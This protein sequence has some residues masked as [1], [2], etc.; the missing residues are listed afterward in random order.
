MK[1]MKQIITLL[2]VVCMLASVV[3]MYAGAEIDRGIGDNL[4]VLG[5]IDADA[6]AVTLNFEEGG[7][8]TC[9]K[10]TG[11]EWWYS[12]AQRWSDGEHW[13]CVDDQDL[14]EDWFSENNIKSVTVTW[15]DGVSV[16]VPKEG[17]VIDKTTIV[18]MI[19]FFAIRDEFKPKPS[20]TVQPATPTPVAPTVQPATP[21]PTATPAAPTVQPATPTPAAP[22]VQPTVVPTVE[23]TADPEAPKT[24]SEMNTLS[25]AFMAIGTLGLIALGVVT[26]KEKFRG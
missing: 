17:I 9:E 11:E 15:A 22:T 1:R 8:L 24:G 23:P 5:N 26:A 4:I 19:L 14:Y 21:T 7:S 10:T 13:A 3:T 25:V 18:D 16:E 6:T 20:P 12:L 2:T